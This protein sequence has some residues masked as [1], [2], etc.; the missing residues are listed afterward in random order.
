MPGF[1]MPNCYSTCKHQLCKLDN[2][3]YFDRIAMDRNDL[4]NVCIVIALKYLYCQVMTVLY[5]F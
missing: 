4:L 1:S 5:F 3:P 2:G